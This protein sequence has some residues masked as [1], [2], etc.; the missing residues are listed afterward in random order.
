[1][2]SA[3]RG[4]APTFVH[5]VGTHVEDSCAGK[6]LRGHPQTP[7]PAFLF[8]RGILRAWSLPSG[9]VLGARAGHFTISPTGVLP[10]PPQMLPFSLPNL[11]TCKEG[12]EQGHPAQDVRP[13]EAPVPEAATQEADGDSSVNGQGQQDKKG[14]REECVGGNR[15]GLGARLRR[16]VWWGG[17]GG[18]KGEDRG[19]KS[20]VGV[21]MVRERE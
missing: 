9:L 10:A 19:V 5:P 2:S 13:G 7:T 21:K 12:H 14:C 8:S 17:W 20:K 11:C 3:G 4:Q 16:G 6:G 15:D 18:E 1:M